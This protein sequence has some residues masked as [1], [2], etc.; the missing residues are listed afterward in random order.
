MKM[1]NRIVYGNY[2]DLRRALFVAAVLMM[3]AA[4][5]TPVRAQL[6]QS[7][8]F[9]AMKARSLG[10]ATSSG[11]VSAIEACYL[12]TESG[13]PLEK[14]LCIYVGAAAG[15]VFKSY[16]NGTTFEPVFD[17]EKEH[18]IG[19]MA[20]DPTHADSVLWVGTGESN[21]RNSVSIGGGLYKTTD[22]GTSW[23][24]LGLDNVERIAKIALVPG[25]PQKAFIAGLGALWS[26]SPNRGLYRTTNGGQSFERVLYVDEKTGCADVVIDPVQPNIMYASMWQFRRKAYTFSSGGPGSGLY[27]ST[28]GGATW[29]KMT[30]TIP[31]GDLGRILLAIAPS[32]HNIVYAMFESSKS[33]LYRSENFGESWKLTST[34]SSV[35]AR[36]FYFSCLQVDPYNENMVYRPSFQLGMSE[37]GGETF[38]GFQYGGGTHPDHHALWID[39]TNPQHLLLGTDGGVYRSYDRGSSWSKF[40]N[41]SLAQFYHVS[42]D[43]EEPY[44][45][46]GGLQ[47]NG[48]WMVPHRIPGGAIQN[49]NWEPTG[50]GDGFW[51]IRDRS[52]AN[53]L[54]FESQ[55][56]N[57]VRRH[58]ATNETKPIKPYEQPGEAKLRWNWSTPLT[59]SPT[60]P[61]R[62]YICSQYVYTSTN[63]GDTWDRISGD[64]TTNDSTKYNPEGSGGVTADNT[65]AE[66][67]CTI[68]TIAESPMDE[69]II[70]AGTDDGNL[71]VTTNGGNTWTLCSSKLPKNV[72]AGTWVSCVEP[73]HYAKGTCYVTLENHTR[74]DMKPYVVRTTDYG[75]TWSA[76]NTDSL[77]GY[78]HVVREDPVNAQL[79]YA[80]T[81]YGLYISMDGG[82]S[83]ALFKGD[84]PVTPVRDLQIHPR[85]HDL[86][87][88]THGRGMYI[89]DDLTPLRAL[90]ADLLKQ[91]I[92][93]LPTRPSLLRSES[94]FQEF[95]GVDEFIAPNPRGDAQITYFLRARHLIGDLKIDILDSSNSVIA[96]VP[97]TKRKGINRVGWGMNMK[98]PKV[99][100]SKNTGGGDFGPTLPAGTY[101][102][103]ITKNDK[104][105]TGPLTIAYDPRSIH[106]G[107][108]RAKNFATTMKLYAL[109]ER[110]AYAAE[111]ITSVRDSL[112]ARSTAGL[113]SAAVDKC[114]EEFDALHKTVVAKKS[115]LFADTEPQLREKLAEIYGDV[116]QST[117]APSDNQLAR[118]QGMALAV[119]ELEKKIDTLVSSALSTANADV[120]KAGAPPVIPISKAEFIA[121]RE[122]E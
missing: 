19:A 57:A 12:P 81:E 92:T 106:S 24:K 48:S 107:S 35:T 14:K 80:G 101:T 116:A 53:I 75:A 83:W 40:R 74:G 5:V 2:T 10:P 62:I 71:H 50:W 26:D 114:I 95:D 15:G 65:S 88:G 103:R 28:D 38:N 110:V 70:W 1:M 63:H 39:P 87:I 21:C 105:V 60:N 29:K 97:A 37:D 96:T 27:K 117:G 86:I 66:N 34:A 49:K 52:D 23:K 102:V 17:K 68:V 113:K 108:D 90:T 91:D 58:I 30:N 78:A 64:L 93:I 45:V 99:A 69:K 16:D 118:V 33:G 120:K 112:E 56:G 20:L 18:S 36:P 43:F 46:F 100:V 98:P 111:Q 115:S 59:Q 51:V 7:S 79:L 119:E 6:T 25:A 77:R 122:Q 72:P 42:Y 94:G 84:F 54:Y 3:A 55:G 61:R 109:I 121:A 47:D 4:A 104:V 22:G 85:E 13:S 32:R 41:L 89:L 8:M 76:L 11:R 31:A 73:G 67:H 44:N 9:G 82:S